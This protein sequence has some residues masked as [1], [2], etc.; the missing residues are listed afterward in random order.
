MTSAA[1]R[2]LGRCF[3]TGRAQYIDIDKLC[4]YVTMLYRGGIL[5]AVGQA[6]IGVD[7]MKFIKK[8]PNLVQQ[9]THVASQY[10]Q[11]N[12]G[13]VGGANISGQ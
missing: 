4:S 11:W 12:K 7:I 13:T 9:I 10:G 8:E 5:S 1:I 3:P 6:H 2:P